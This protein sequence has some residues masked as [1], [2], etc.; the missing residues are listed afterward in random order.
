MEFPSPATQRRG[1]SEATSR[2]SAPEKAKRRLV[3]TLRLNQLRAIDFLVPGILLVGALIFWL[4]SGEP[5]FGDID[6]GGDPHSSTRPKFKH[7]HA[8]LKAAL[9]QH[10]PERIAEHAM[11][12]VQAQIAKN[13]AE[14]HGY[15]YQEPKQEEEVRDKNDPYYADPEADRHQ[16]FSFLRVMAQ[17]C[18]F[19]G[20]GF[21]LLAIWG[22][23]TADDPNI[24][25]LKVEELKKIR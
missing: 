2:A 19:F 11:K 9:E 7:E 18:L 25:P 13:H 15:E 10:T 8:M 14:H 17:A 12:H 24:K 22:S 21:L 20:V 5:L 6:D 3:E 1:R 16:E 4:S 23:I